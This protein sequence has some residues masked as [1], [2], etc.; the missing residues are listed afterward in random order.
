MAFERILLLC[1]SQRASGCSGTSPMG[2]ERGSYGQLAA[3]GALQP[4][5]RLALTTHV[6]AWST[7]GEQYEGAGQCQRCLC[8]CRVRVDRQL[9]TQ[10]QR[11]AS[12]PS[13][14]RSP[15]KNALPT[16]LLRKQQGAPI[17]LNAYPEES[18]RG[19]DV[20]TV[21]RG[22][23]H[24]LKFHRAVVGVPLWQPCS[25]GA[26]HHACCPVPIQGNGH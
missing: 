20:H 4:D 21:H 1:D 17:L 8:Y 14:R 11:Q 24:L 15:H 18:V 22:A 3:S 26:V 6:N 7:A 2:K 9:Q 10:V 13:S 12:V 19:P 5:C 16:S 23:V 25:T